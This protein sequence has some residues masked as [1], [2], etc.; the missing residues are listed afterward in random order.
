M[1]FLRDNLFLVVLTAGTVVVSAG[2]L[3]WGWSVSDKIDVQEMAP[4]RKLV[5]RLKQLSRRPYVNVETNNSDKQLVENIDRSLRGVRQRNIEWNSR[6]FKV[7]TL[8]LLRGGDTPALPYDAKTWDRNTLADQFVVAYHKSLNKMLSR[9]RATTPPSERQIKAEAQL[10]EDTIRYQ[11]RIRS[12]HV[13][14]ES[15]A[16][17]QPGGFAPGAQPF[18]APRRGAADAN[19][20]EQA[21]AIALENMR[22]RQAR[23]GQVYAASDSFDDVFPLRDIVS[24]IEP[25][26]IW[27]AQ[28]GLWVQGDIV[29]ALARTIE[30][31]MDKQGLA[32]SDRNVLNSPIRRLEKIELIWDPS[33]ISAGRSATDAGR[34]PG[35]MPGMPGMPGAMPAAPSR[36]RG[37]TR[38]KS[39]PEE[40]LPVPA[41][42]TRNTDN[43]MLNVANYKF[44]V[45]M[46]TRYLPALE[47]NLLKQNY[48][49]ILNEEIVPPS[50][51]EVKTRA[52]ATAAPAE[53]MYYYGTEPLCRVTV[54]GQLLLLADWVRGSWDEEHGGWTRLPLM[55]V[56]V[57]ET[58][59]P[60]ALRKTDQDLISQAK[61]VK[62]GQ[63]LDQRKPTMPWAQ[64]SRSE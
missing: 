22:Y 45:L 19:V 10:Q 42:L 17:A 3:A 57:L 59:P 47:R 37:R 8:K 2:L 4:R 16:A 62:A 43:K 11:Q 56:E 23:A 64:P 26:K 30:E 13:D 34:S 20:S 12:K 9:L 21:M 36:T 44:T 38:Q 51:A 60:P 32:G 40:K 7:P 15:K 31:T 61:N 5:T 18:A 41:T 50:R 35:F 53:D 49:I 6:N 39:A 1:R 25:A 24:Y 54:T 29:E 63:K 28:V 58:L 55:P 27:Q 46:P 33:Q 48:H 52:S 14:G